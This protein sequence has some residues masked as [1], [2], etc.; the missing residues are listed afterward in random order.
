MAAR[1]WLSILASATALL[2]GE[3]LTM[4][5]QLGLIA[6]AE[7]RPFRRIVAE[8]TAKLSAGRNLFW[9]KVDCGV[10]LFY[11]TWPDAVHEHA[12]TVL[13]AAGS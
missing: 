4:R 1:P 10:R 6:L 12:V 7:L 9:P 3:R 5:F 2:C 11:A 8:P 13:D